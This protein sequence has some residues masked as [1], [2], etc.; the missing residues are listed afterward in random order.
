[1]IFRNF[2]VQMAVQNTVAVTPSTLKA[3]HCTM[4]VLAKQLSATRVNLVP[5]FSQG[6]IMKFKDTTCPSGFTPPRTFLHTEGQA[7]YHDGS[8][9]AVS[10]KRYLGAGTFLSL[11]CGA[12]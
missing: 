7:L 2:V 4:I 1:M 11:R 5:R 6:M 10:D 12:D 8:R 3:K 9:Q